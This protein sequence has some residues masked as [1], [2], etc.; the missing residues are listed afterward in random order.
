MPSLQF[1]ETDRG[2]SLTNGSLTV[3]V[4]L[5]KGTYDIHSATPA[6]PT[7]TNAAAT[8][9]LRGGPTFSTR[10]EDLEF[11]GTTDVSD[12]HGKG[13]SL[14]LTREAA[15]TEP[16][17]HIVIT[18]YERQPFVIVHTEIQNPASSP[19]RVQEF[20][21]LDGATLETE[22]KALRF[23]KH[24]WQSWSPTVVLDCSGTD[25]VT[26]PPVIGPGTQPESREGRFTS[27]L[28]TAIVDP[29]TNHG[30][31][32]GFTSNT[33]QFSHVWFDWNTSSLSAAS[34]AD[35]IEVRQRG[36][37]SSE[38]LYVELT[39]DP[40][41]SLATFGDA[42]ATE[43]DAHPPAAVPSGWCSWYY[44]WQGIS[45]SEMIANLEHISTNRESLPF[46]Y[47][48]LD[49]GY[50]SEI[51]DWLTPNEKFPNGMKWLAGQIHSRGFKA[52][53]WLAPFIAGEKSCL[54]RDHPD[55]FVQSPSGD[56]ALAIQNWGQ[57]CYAL[58][59]TNPTVAHLA[60]RRLPHDLR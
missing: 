44:Y 7:I 54:F 56:P 34:Y 19:L 57:D 48:Q 59:L 45:E 11:V 37:L 15:E 38:P 21:P 50:Q 47:I 33:D 26:A 2:L 8:V 16:E 27:D 39:G 20:R 28:V 18:L 22:T 51:G 4:H 49:D 36:V 52:G 17:L 58:D 23:Y 53:L 3:E 32:V 25:V 13:V 12:V 43:M 5:N 60:P 24:G 14:L 55:W 9:I 42:L 30:A 6:I 31:V 10:G 41:H 35:G 46:E 29:S 1:E 40:V